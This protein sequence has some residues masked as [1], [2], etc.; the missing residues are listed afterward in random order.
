[1]Q[2]KLLKTAP[3]AIATTQVVAFSKEPRQLRAVSML[4]SA[5]KWTVDRAQRFQNGLYFFNNK[6]KGKVKQPEL[7]FASLVTS[8]LFPQVK[9]K[10]TVPFIRGK[11][12]P[13]LDSIDE[14]WGDS[15]ASAMVS[16]KR[17]DENKRF[18]A[19]VP[20]LAFGKGGL[21]AGIAK[22]AFLAS[23]DLGII[24]DPNANFLQ[25]EQRANELS[26][27]DH[28]FPVDNMTAV[29]N[30]SD[31][32]VKTSKDLG[33]AL[34]IRNT[35]TY[36]IVLLEVP[37]SQR[38][39]ES[40]CNSEWL[41]IRP[42]DMYGMINAWV[43]GYYGKRA[44]SPASTIPLVD[45]AKQSEG[46]IALPRLSKEGVLVNEDGELY[47]VPDK[48]NSIYQYEDATSAALTHADGSFG[49]FGPDGVKAA[50]PPAM[51]VFVDW[52]NLKFA[53]TSLDG[54]LLVM[55]LDR[56]QPL[57]ITHARRFIETRL[58]KSVAVNF[59]TTALK[60]ANFSG[61]FPKDQ[62]SFFD[63]LM[64]EVAQK[65]MEIESYQSVE[66]IPLVSIIEYSVPNK[67][68]DGQNVEPG[69]LCAE[70]VAAMHQLRKFVEQSPTNAYA[71]YSVTGV[72]TLL[73][74]LKVFLDYGSRYSEVITE[75]NTKRKAYMNQGEDPNFKLAPVPLIEPGRGLLPHQS[76]VQNLLRESPDNAMLPVDAGG[77]KT[78][79]VVYEILRE[80]SMLDDLQSLS[81]VMCPSH[82]VAQYVKEFNY[83]TGSRVNVIPVTSYTIRRQGFKRLEA[84]IQNAP[85]NSIVISDYNAIL[86]GSSSVAYG[87]AVVRTFPVIEFLRQFFYKFVACDESHYLKNGSSRNAAV[88]R[89]I[90]DI[91]KKRLASGTMV[92]DTITDLVRQTAL[93]DPTVFGSEAE[94]IDN[95]AQET[96][97]SKVVKWKDGAELSIKRQLS[98][99]VVIAEAKRKEWA[100]ILPFPRI[101][102]HPVELSQKQQLAYHEVLNK[103]IETLL[104]K[105]KENKALAA[106]LE[107]KV[108][109]DELGADL[110]ALMKPYLAR[111][112]RFITA[113]G[114]DPYGA[115]VLEGE[116]KISPKIHE[117]NNI[118]KEHLAE[119]RPGKV[120]IFTNYELSTDAIWEGLAIAGLQDQAI[121]YTAGNKDECGA[122]F[123]KNPK[124]KIMVGIE[125]SLNTGLNLQ[126]CSVLIR[127][128]SVW[129]PG[130]MEQGNSRIGRPNI[131]VRE[132]RK[133]I[134]YHTITANRTIDV[135]KSA[136]LMAKTVSK[137]KFDEAGNPRFDEL[138]TP[139][140]L[141]M[142]LDTIQSENDWDETMRDYFE[143]FQS[144]QQALAAEYAE[145]REKNASKLFDE[146]GNLKI[147]IIERSA[148]P[149]GS[150]LMRRVPYVPGT[151]LYKASELGLLRYD[152]FLSKHHAAHV[153]DEEEEGGLDDE[154][155][156]EDDD[157]EVSEK[158]LSAEKLAALQ[159]ERELCLGLSVH[160]DHGDGEIVRVSAKTLLVKLPSGDVIKV[161]KLAA[162]IITRANTSNKDIRN[163]L[164]KLTG[165]VPLDK[166]IDVLETQ[167]VPKIEEAAK[168]NLEK[169]KNR[170]TEEAIEMELSFTVA[171]DFL[172]VSMDN[173]SDE[174]AV[175]VAQ[176]L[177]F[178]FTP[179]Y[180]AA[181]VKM[182]R[183]MLNFFRI[184]KDQEFEVDK[185]GN[186]ACAEAF[187]HFRQNKTMPNLFFGYA[188]SANIRNFFRKEFK[189][190]ADKMYIQPYPLIQDGKLYLCLP[191]NGHPGSVNAIRKAQA[192]GL[193]WLVYDEDS[194]LI[195]FVSTKSQA[196]ALIQKIVSLGI[197]I[198]NVKAL[199][200][201]FMSLRMAVRKDQDEE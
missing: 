43:N 27:G 119:N 139:P 38:E 51:P 26:E 16:I 145:Y 68:H 70:F 197:N 198:R 54:K 75:D 118:I 11:F 40:M 134:Y 107:G 13:V 94:F 87:T 29:G 72:C 110:D 159:A 14:T 90:I 89:L 156:G 10:A 31:Q 102:F 187:L 62:R 111:L 183:Q 186:Q 83:F 128:E 53:Y 133:F 74:Q 113:P 182:P 146:N 112:E 5:S 9:Q 162:F 18:L 1:M 34:L 93:M 76:K 81:L 150:A 6:F 60:L 100:A 47:A 174:R 160:T 117:I 132:E 50:L 73:G 178:K 57:N 36:T 30:L 21:P 138:E 84:M 56:S 195:N 7:V 92:A 35:A 99:H 24:S 142:T 157:K 96:R 148:N 161:R 28:R 17:D 66:E 175:K 165:D 116:D 173:I 88:G 39:C 137:A 189:P 124:K 201:Q 86:L 12:K 122:E 109:P 184:L 15:G 82:L 67:G 59:I 61:F 180:Y 106:L 45:I 103:V 179:A 101:F 185:E 176:G 44:R 163:Q 80:I 52:V 105:A 152:D 166:P 115:T 104:E 144:Y 48:L 172:G 155:G 33:V 177:G 147:D 25:V 140:L 22:A 98:Q 37:F 149:E 126:F 23:G 49:T 19:T 141:K 55:N 91:K 169:Q 131:K 164:L 135:T 123:E 4:K 97:G 130:V 8:V 199:K 58:S 2:I 46:K 125:Q 32:L 170:K 3:R 188:S 69:P 121:Y 171:N 127:V 120:L 114:K 192:S 196:S 136:Y 143:K 108:D 158:D 63:A 20:I 129:T 194:E 42:L 200:K 78:A 71:R 191:K 193:K 77:G 167:I 64:R 65:G 181:Q 168:E 95:Y 41:T 153:E 85:P 190:K 151:E 154:D 79:L